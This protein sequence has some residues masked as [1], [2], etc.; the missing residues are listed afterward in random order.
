MLASKITCVPVRIHTFTGLLFPTKKGIFKQLLIGMDRILCLTST[1]IYAEGKGVKNDLIQY[2]ISKKPINIIAY[3]NVNGIDCDYFNPLAINIDDKSKL[4]DKLGISE[5]DFVYLFVGRLVKD[6]GINEL[7][8]AF[9]ELAQEKFKLIMLGD[10][11][12]DLDPLAE[13]TIKIIESNKNI[14]TP[15]FVDDVRLYFSI[16]DVFVFPSYRE[17]FPNVVLQAGAMSLPSI[18][19]DINGSNEIIKHNFN[20]I[21]IP[22]KNVKVLMDSMLLLYENKIFRSYL[23]ANS[24]NKIVAKYNQKMIWEAVK[25]EYDSLIRCNL[26]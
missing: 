9:Q 20:G 13:I 17:G 7:V 1:N 15:G 8:L 19:T 5:S 26:N 22:C 23:S 3:G 11:E 16:S 4:R 6:K 18:V 2:R 14:I 25:N 21:I 12:N 10:Y 24:R